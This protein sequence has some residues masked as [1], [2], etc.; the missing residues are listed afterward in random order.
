MVRLPRKIHH[1]VFYGI[2]MRKALFGLFL[3]SFLLC[4][5]SAKA[6]PKNQTIQ[7]KQYLVL[8]GGAR[9]ISDNTIIYRPCNQ[10]NECEEFELRYV[11]AIAQEIDSIPKLEH[12]GKIMSE[13]NKD[14]NLDSVQTDFDGNYSFKCPT[15]KCLVLSVGQAGSAYGYWLKTVKANSKVD[16]TNSNAIYIH[17]RRN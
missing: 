13:F 17:N 9:P 5:S 7:G 11:N 14:D 3:L 4:P 15:S 16:L 1:A 6:N 8:G 10:K 2:A 12:L